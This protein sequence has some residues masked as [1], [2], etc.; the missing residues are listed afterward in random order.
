M[1]PPRRCVPYLAVLLV[2]L[3]AVPSQAAVFGDGNPRNGPEDDRIP[4]PAENPHLK[5]LQATGTIEC[6]GVVRGSGT[7]LDT[8]DFADP[9]GWT[10]IVTV[11]HIFFETGT[12]RR[13][14]SCIF[15]PY[16]G[17]DYRRQIDLNYAVMGDYVP[18][19]NPKTDDFI[20][21]WAVLALPAQ[22]E[23]FGGALKPVIAPEGKAL[24]QA[25]D[26]LAVV[27]YDRTERKQAVS[28]NCRIVPLPPQLGAQ[29]R[30]KLYFTDCDTEPGASGG[31]VSYEKD[32]QF[33]LIG[34]YSGHYWRST[35][36]DKAAHPNGPPEG[37]RFNPRTNANLFRVFD[38]Q[39]VNAVRELV[40][41]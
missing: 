35:A 31:A 41:R 24:A 21:D 14:G 9:Q 13:R 3:L 19:S 22:L 34:T 32:G 40:A 17:R 39:M 38:Q 7:V 26:G 36:A 11:A 10:I 6:D 8:S 5:A 1:T 18:W 29:A 23:R 12:H 33:Y 27:G 2:A 20:N 16:L 25:R 15:I 28:L 4:V 30:T 37:S